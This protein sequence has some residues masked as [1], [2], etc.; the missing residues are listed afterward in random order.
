MKRG[1]HH[2]TEA[3]LA[4]GAVEVISST[5]RPV[6]WSPRHGGSLRGF[7]DDIAS[8]GYGNNQTTYLSFHQMGSARIGSNPANS[9][10]DQ[11]NQVPDTPGIYVMDA[12][13]FPLASGV[14]P[15]ISIE[16]IAHRG[17]RALAAQLT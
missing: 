2:A 6:R 3:L 15:M 16:T 10:V 14:N 12:S 7:L 1:V 13:T 9:V 5:S 8:I 17:A 11:E 4:A